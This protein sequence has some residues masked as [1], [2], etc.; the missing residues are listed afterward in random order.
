MSTHRSFALTAVSSWV[1][2]NTRE[3]SVST[4]THSRR[5]CSSE[6]TEWIFFSSVLL[7][8]SLVDSFLLLIRYG[9]AVW[10]SYSQPQ[11]SQSLVKRNLIVHWFQLSKHIKYL[12]MV[13]I[14]IVEIIVII[15]FIITNCISSRTVGICWLSDRFRARPQET[16]CHTNRKYPRQAASRRHWSYSIPVAKGL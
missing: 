2:Q 6:T 11:P 13:I 3:F 8:Y 15:S 12:I 5:N 16:K 1:T 7:G 14:E 9:T 4:A 10:C